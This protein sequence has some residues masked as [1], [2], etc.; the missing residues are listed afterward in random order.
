MMKHCGA[1]PMGGTKLSEIKGYNRLKTKEDLHIKFKILSYLLLCHM[2]SLEI[3][4]EMFKI[5][6]LN[7]S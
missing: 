1:L 3:E 4:I 7:I 6:Y 2:F 5:L